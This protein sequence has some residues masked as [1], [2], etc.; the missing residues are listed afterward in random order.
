MTRPPRA[1]AGALLSF[2]A[3]LALLGAPSAAQTGA[4]DDAPIGDPAAAPPD[5][6]GTDRIEN[7]DRRDWTLRLEPGVWLVSPAGELRMPGA[8]RD[9]VRVEELNLDSPRAR[10]AGELHLAAE[11]FRF[12]FSAS[13]FGL[14]PDFVS[15]DDFDLGDVSIATGDTVDVDFDLTM[16]ELA[17]GRLVY[18]RDFD[19]LSL[20]PAGAADF[21][22]RV[23]ALAGLRL[24][25]LDIDVRETAPAAARTSTDQFFGEAFIG[26]R[27]EVEI[28][29]DFSM[30]LQL[31][32]GA[33]LDSDRSVTS[34]DI[35]VGF[36]WR[37]H[38]NMGIQIGWRQLAFFLEDGDGADTFEYEGTMAGIQ[39]GVE[40]RF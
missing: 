22:L 40:I 2:L 3:A 27:A 23:Y 6:L 25:D 4:A 35:V 10:P 37:P 20:D 21:N 34:F 31:S 18:Q 15:E 36:G 32:G 38:P 12:S 33:Y 1:R 28:A 5:P 7:L 11:P 13:Q 39:A 9:R 8:S 26:A 30:D 19:A 17:A 14:E 16:I 29:R 24:Y